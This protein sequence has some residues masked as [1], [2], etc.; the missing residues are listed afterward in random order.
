VREIFDS[1]LR[2][3]RENEKNLSLASLETIEV[4][5]AKSKGDKK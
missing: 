1:A 3:Q 2:R 5:L 4:R